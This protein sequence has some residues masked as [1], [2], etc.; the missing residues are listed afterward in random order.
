MQGEAFG[1]NVTITENEISRVGYQRYPAKSD[2]ELKLTQEKSP[3]GWIMVLVIRNKPK[4]R[5]YRD[6]LMTV[7]G[8]EEL[9]KTNVLPVE[10]NLSDFES[11]PHPIVQLALRD[12]HFSE[13]S[14]QSVAGD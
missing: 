11:W 13:K 3:S 9:F 6:A 1:I 10:P 14:T 2:V 4:R 12:F 7:P 5:L 8:K